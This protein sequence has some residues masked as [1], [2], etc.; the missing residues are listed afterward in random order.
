[1]KKVKKLIL[2]IVIGVIIALGA[3]MANT[4][5]NEDKKERE[6]TIKYAYDDKEDGWKIAFKINLYSNGKRSYS[7]NGYNL[8]YD[9]LDGY[10]IP[11]V[12]KDTGEIVEKIKPKTITLSVSEKYSEEV[13]AIN[14]YFN[15][16]QF[17]TSIS[18]YDLNDLSLKNIDKDYLVNLFNR[19]I[20]SKEIE[21][22]GNYADSPLSDCIKVESTEESMPGTWRL[23]YIIDYGNISDIYIDFIS[24]DGTHLKDKKK[25]NEKEKNI[26]SEITELEHSLIDKLN[27]K[28]VM[29]KE[30]NTNYSVIAKEYVALENSSLPKNDIQ[31]LIE[32]TFK[33]LNK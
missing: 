33:S 3:V 7:F 8:K 18:L 26:T 25:M 12:D 30:K 14:K 24:K 23:F 32:D 4:I 10:Y 9:E 16:K 11:M 17:M 5:D 27:Q 29:S 19:A 21:E 1:M 28:S 20:N 31:K 13:L 22:P 6:F 15:E 2:F